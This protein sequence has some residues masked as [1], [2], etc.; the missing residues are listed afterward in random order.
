MRLF[1]SIFL[2]L[3][4]TTFSIQAQQRIIDATNQLPVA[5]ASIFDHSGNMVGF[6]WNDGTLS[7]IPTSVYPISIRCMGYETITIPSPDQ[8]EWSMQPK[9]YELEEVV[10]IPV[11]RNVLK[12]TFYVR[13]FFS[14]NTQTDTITYYTEHMADRF[15][16]TSKDTKFRGDPMLRTLNSRTYARYRIEDI[17]SVFCEKNPD[18]PSML[19][20]ID[21][22]DESYTAP[23]SFKASSNTTQLYEKPGKSGPSI[24]YKQ[25]DAT[26]SVI[27]DGLADKKNHSWSPWP[28]KLLGLTMEIKQFFFAYAFQ[29]NEKG[30]Y[31]AKDLTE[32]N[33]VIEAEGRGK[34]IRKILKSE[35][36]ITM[37]VMIELYIV[38]RDYLSDEEAKEESKST[39]KNVEFVIPS[40]V[41]PL[42]AATHKMVE[43]AKSQAKE[44]N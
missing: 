4:I 42:N 44:G 21:F 9:S 10:V 2:G 26:F 3:L 40:T 19:T 20:I 27:E 17:D 38:D 22:N 18:L 1:L 5:A 34:H 15:I 11:K 35:K 6:T 32:S 28:F 37:R 24:I 31:E 14:M 39:P 25:N 8:E 16:R 23:E 41:P 7:D 30:V 43:R 13:E 33:I 29:A 12:Q 36:P